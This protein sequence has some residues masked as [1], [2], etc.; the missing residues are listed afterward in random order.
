M[1]K[2]GDELLYRENDAHFAIY[3]YVKKKILE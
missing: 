1:K 3:L 2:A